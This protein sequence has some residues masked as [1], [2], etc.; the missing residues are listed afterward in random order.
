MFY[1]K[2][3]ICLYYKSTI[4]SKYVWIIHWCFR[5][6]WGKQG[7]MSTN[8]RRIMPLLFCLLSYVAQSHLDETMHCTLSWPYVV[9]INV[10][11]KLFFGNYVWCRYGVNWCWITTIQ[12]VCI[13]VL[14]YNALI[15]RCE[16]YL[17]LSCINDNVSHVFNLRMSKHPT[18]LGHLECN[19]I[20]V[21]CHLC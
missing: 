3:C 8:K 10:M 15:A 6:A 19:S 16:T 12:D 2:T 17:A 14:I 5:C 21:D 20:T 1:Y 11:Q 13:K 9:K 4:S 7:G 18:W